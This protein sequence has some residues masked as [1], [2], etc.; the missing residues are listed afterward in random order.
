MPTQTRLV[1]E[2]YILY[3][4]N[5]KCSSNSNGL[6][7]LK[8]NFPSSQNPS[9]LNKAVRSMIDRYFQEQEENFSRILKNV[10]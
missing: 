6:A 9:S 3:K 2:D 10:M 7:Q 4:I 1:I 5:A 8:Q